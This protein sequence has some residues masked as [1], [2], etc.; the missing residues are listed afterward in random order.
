MNF[1]H[2][3]YENCDTMKIST[4]CKHQAY[5]S[6]GLEHAKIAIN[7]E[8]NTLNALIDALNALIDTLDVLI[9]TLGR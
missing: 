8:I 4:I 3:R 7:A 6:K 9:D 1:Q 5:N 2:I